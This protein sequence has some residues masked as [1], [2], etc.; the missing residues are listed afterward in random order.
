MEN[1]LMPFCERLILSDNQISLRVIIFSSM[2]V[3]VGAHA[4]QQEHGY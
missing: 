2:S 3:S 4:L 1:I